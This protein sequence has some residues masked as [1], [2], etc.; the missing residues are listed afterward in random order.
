MTYLKDSEVHLDYAYALLFLCLFVCLFISLQEKARR[1]FCV[2][3]GD[4][5]T[6][7]NVYQAF[8]RVSNETS[9][10]EQVVIAAVLVLIAADCTLATD[11]ILS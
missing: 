9:K 5:L 7:L 2:H 10:E 6:L 11:M 4:H 1:M 3:E 8:L